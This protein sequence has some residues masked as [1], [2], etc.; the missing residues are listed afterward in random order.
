MSPDDKILFER[1]RNKRDAEAFRCLADRYA[2]MVYA[3]GRR[4]T[5][6]PQDAEDVAQATFEALATQRRAPR[7]HL[8]AWLHR[9]AT[10]RALNLLRTE[11]RRRQ[12][13][14]AYQRV[15]PKHSDVTWDDIYDLVDEAVAALPAGQ[16]DVVVASFLEGHTHEQIARQ[17]GLSRPA[18]T[19][20]VQKG[21]AGIRRA[22][23]RKGVRVPIAILGGLLSRAASGATPPGM[24]AK[25]GKL[26]LSGYT[27]EA[28]FAQGAW[29]LL[30]S[31]LA[32]AKAL[33]LAA[34]V[35]GIAVSVYF[36]TTN[37]G[38]EAGAPSGTN[39]ATPSNPVLGS[40]D[41]SIGK[42]IDGMLTSF[43]K[44]GGETHTELFPGIPPV[45]TGTVVDPQGQPLPGVGV[46]GVVTTT[47]ER[48]FP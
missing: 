35:V 48:N 39:N 7:V 18:V 36:V 19:Q 5:G 30:G 6:K 33:G 45:L 16:R 8:G 1:W 46:R 23:R 40:S 15:R 22:L 13:E 43:L 32:S 44:G 24:A 37:A 26:S 14:E 31:G 42:V 9:V 11:R 28:A 41:F 27:G 17:L 20:R 38:Q 21:I 47:V 25:L 2:G 3:T 10:Y 29:Q 12:H 34:T 4:L